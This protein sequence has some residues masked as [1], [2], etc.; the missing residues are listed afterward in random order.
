[1]DEHV[2]S[3]MD[4]AKQATAKV[5]VL[6][7]FCLGDGMAFALPCRAVPVAAWGAQFM[8][9]CYCQAVLWLTTHTNCSAGL[10]QQQQLQLH[11]PSVAPARVSGGGAAQKQQNWFLAM[12][13]AC[14]ST[15]VLLETVC[16]LP[17][18]LSIIVAT[19][20]H[21]AAGGFPAG[22][23]EAAGGRCTSTANEKVGL[24]CGSKSKKLQ[25]QSS[26]PLKSSTL[27]GGSG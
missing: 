1:L 25:T 20:V 6:P 16:S 14:A 3:F 17:C 5:G 12:I 21:A 11:Q 13:A 23:E 15:W 4:K 10:C 19:L 8:S 27:H 18:S 26:F 24:E 7:G 22:A 2:S 9:P